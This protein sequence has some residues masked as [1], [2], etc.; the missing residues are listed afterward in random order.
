VIPA[1]AV[2]SYISIASRVEKISPLAIKGIGAVRATAREIRERP[3]G[4]ASYISR[5]VREWRIMSAPSEAGTHKLDLLERS[6]R[7]AK[8]YHPA[9]A[10]FSRQRGTNYTAKEVTN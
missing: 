1:Q 4:C 10:K 5:T 7:T 6:D 9:H 8:Q 3:P 2:A